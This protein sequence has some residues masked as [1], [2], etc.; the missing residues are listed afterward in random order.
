MVNILFSTSLE[1][2]EKKHQ[3]T[4]QNQYFPHFISYLF[5]VEN[6]SYVNYIFKVHIAQKN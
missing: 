3:K 1:T 4:Q 2:G 6:I 5:A